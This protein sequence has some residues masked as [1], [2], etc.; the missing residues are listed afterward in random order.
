LERERASKAKMQRELQEI[1]K[2]IIF[3]GVGDFALVQ[4]RTYCKL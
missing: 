3:G 4:V 1:K 2:D